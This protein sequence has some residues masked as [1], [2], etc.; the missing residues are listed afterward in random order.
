MTKQF[1]TTTVLAAVLTA[2]FTSC[3]KDEVR[4][5]ATFSA[6]P[7]VS[8]SSTNAG[9]LLK[10]NSA[11]DAVTYTWTPY[12]FTLSDDTKSNSPVTYTL[13]MGLAGTNFATPYELVA[14]T[15]TASSLKLTV[16]QL[17]A[18]LINLKAPLAR[19]SQLEVRLKTFVASNEPIIY[20]NSVTIGATPYD[21]CVAPNS[22]TWSLIGLAGVDWNT[23]VALTWSC[24]ENA[25]VVRRALN[26]DEFKFRRNNDWAVNLGAAGSGV[27]TLA[28]GASTALAS[29]NPP[30]LKIGTAGTYTIKLR[31]TGTGAG[32]TGTVTIT[33]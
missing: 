22:D 27:A 4:T 2:G 3:K 31:V 26:A 29:G 16:G 5:V 11:A 21:E 1:F 20:S 9:V 13:Q 18:A 28:P 19:A 17:N 12:T 15:G 32:T 30:N 10:A 6:A 23:D 24:A 14:G 33:P 25:Y 7:T 8:S